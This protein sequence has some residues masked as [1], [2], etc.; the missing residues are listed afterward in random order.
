MSGASRSASAS[1]RVKEEVDQLAIEPFG[2]H[3]EDALYLGAMGRHF[4]G[5]EAEERP[6]RG[7]TQIAGADGHAPL[8]LQ[9]IQ[10]GG[11]ERRVKFLEGS[12]SGMCADASV[13]SA[14]AA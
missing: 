2:R 7:Q 3:R 5:G 8:F 9:F 13:R 12:L 10:E 4:I 6:D 1:G 14:A 11:D